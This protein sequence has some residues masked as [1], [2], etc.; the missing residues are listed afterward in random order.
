M[1]EAGLQSAGSC[2]CCQLGVCGLWG[3]YVS[4]SL[5]AVIQV[6]GWDLPL[7][8]IGC[9]HL[10]AKAHAE[11]MTHKLWCMFEGLLVGVSS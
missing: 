6:S 10:A 4:I 11:C 3:V 9:A 5:P 8:F 1:Q 2:L 7:Q